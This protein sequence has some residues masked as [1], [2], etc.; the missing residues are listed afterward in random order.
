MSHFLVFWPLNENQTNISQIIQEIDFLK[1]NSLELVAIN[2]SSIYDQHPL[3]EN[4]SN[5]LR[6]EINNNLPFSNMV[7]KKNEY[8]KFLESFCAFICGVKKFVAVFR[9]QGKE[10]ENSLNKLFENPIFSN[11]IQKC[12]ESLFFNNSKKKL[13][14]QEAKEYQNFVFTQSFDIIFLKIELVWIY[15]INI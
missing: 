12:S 10:D 6:A 11:S 3:N 4:S 2:H 7:K 14:N 1:K 5:I 8:Q 15:S 9:S 13:M